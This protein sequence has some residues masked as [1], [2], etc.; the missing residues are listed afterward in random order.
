VRVNWRK[1]LYEVDGVTGQV[2]LPLAN[3]KHSSIT[4]TWKNLR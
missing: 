2:P 4:D 1:G 3:R